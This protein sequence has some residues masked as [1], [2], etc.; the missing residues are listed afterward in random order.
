MHL[1]LDVRDGGIGLP[2]LLART[3]RSSA[4][5]VTKPVQDLRLFTSL[6][7]LISKLHSKQYAPV[8]MEAREAR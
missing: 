7:L 2:M 8:L 4:G 3:R 1:G 5:K 6:I